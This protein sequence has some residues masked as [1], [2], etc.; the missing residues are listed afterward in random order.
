[1]PQRSPVLLRGLVGAIATRAKAGFVAPQLK[2]HFDFLEAE[3]GRAQWFAGA[4]FSAAD[5][6]MSF[7]LEAGAARAGALEGRPRLK[8][9]VERI[10]A[11]PAFRAALEKGG[12]YAYA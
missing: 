1:M 12:P 8:A 2:T 9:F 3:L 5:V 10:H 7:P 4:E 6:M 11:R